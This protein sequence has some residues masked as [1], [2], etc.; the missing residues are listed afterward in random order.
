MRGYLWTFAAVIAWGMEYVLIKRATGVV[1]PFLVGAAIFGTAAILLWV[2]AFCVR[3]PL[4]PIVAHWRRLLLIG[5]MGSGCNL[6]AITGTKLTT[7]ANAAVLSRT[8][9]MFTL[10]LSLILFGRAGGWRTLVSLPVMLTGVLLTMRVDL[11]QVQLGNT[12][13]WLILGGALFLACNA[14]LIK[15]VMHRV[16][17]LQVAAVNCVVNVAVFAAAFL[18]LESVS[19]LGDC[20]ASIWGALVICGAC[21]FLFFVGYYSALRVMPVWEVRLLCLGVPV[22]AALTGWAAFGVVPT[23]G[24]I[25]GAVLILGGAATIILGGRGSGAPRVREGRMRRP[26]RL[27]T[28]ER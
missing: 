19:M 16:H 11:H 6:L 22:V 28:A 25:V 2:A 18:S 14:F 12:G 7:V 9:V 24:Q 10:L 20:P 3:V 13:D 17:G 23:G 8:D 1:S 21:C 5:L 15:D 4:Q 27:E 26:C